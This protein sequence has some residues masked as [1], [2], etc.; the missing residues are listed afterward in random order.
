MGGFEGGEGRFGVGWVLGFDGEDFLEE[1]GFIV[2]M[3][4]VLF[5]EVMGCGF[6]GFFGFW[7]EGVE[8]VLN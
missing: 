1:G 2:G 4:V 3:F 8:V 5:D 6:D 7:V